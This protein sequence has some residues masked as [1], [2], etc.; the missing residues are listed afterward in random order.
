[1]KQLMDDYFLFGFSLIKDANESYAVQNANKDIDYLALGIP[2]VGNH[3]KTTEEL[4]EA[5]CGYFHE[6]V[7]KIRKLGVE[8]KNRLKT[9]SLEVYQKRFSNKRFKEVL[10]QAFKN[11]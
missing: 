1:L 7:E 4:I 11:L 5:G 2:I 3:R 6:D 8:E 9:R 10:N